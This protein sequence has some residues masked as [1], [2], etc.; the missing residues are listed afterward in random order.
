[1]HLH[2]ASSRSHFRIC[3]AKN[4][5]TV[6]RSGSVSGSISV[7]AIVAADAR[8]KS[9]NGV[10][11]VRCQ[12]LTGRETLFR[13]LLA[14]D[15]LGFFWT[16]ADR[17]LHSQVRFGERCDAAEICDSSE[18]WTNGDGNLVY[19]RLAPF[20]RCHLGMGSASGKSRSKVRHWA[21]H[22]R[23]PISLIFEAIRR[24]PLEAPGSTGFSDLCSLV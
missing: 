11:K 21:T 10:F 4:S 15:T 20:C 24:S 16:E 2:S 1:M 3:S 19:N 6:M 13:K 17:R 14:A 18:R 22:H 9:R 8:R 12:S 7:A 5:C 23:I